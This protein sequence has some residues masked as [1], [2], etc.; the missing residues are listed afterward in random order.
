MRAAIEEFSADSL[1]VL[2]DE[3]LRILR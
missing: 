1:A 3:V 2:G